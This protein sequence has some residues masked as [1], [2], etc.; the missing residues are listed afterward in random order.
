MK[1][2]EIRTI[3]GP[4]FIERDQG[5][6]IAGVS[7]YSV[8]AGGERVGNYAVNMARYA[9]WVTPVV[10]DYDSDMDALSDGWENE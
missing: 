6:K 3:L 8:S 4:V 5:W 10:I 1:P 2:E 7:L 9:G